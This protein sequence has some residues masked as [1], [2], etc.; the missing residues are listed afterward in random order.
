VLCAVNGVDLTGL[1]EEAIDLL[2]SAAK[3][4]RSAA[5]PLR[6]L[7]QLP[8]WPSHA[9]A[10]TATAGAGHAAGV[11]QLDK[12]L[13]EHESNSNPQPNRLPQPPSTQVLSSA[14]HLEQELKEELEQKLREQDERRRRWQQVTC[15]RKEVDRHPNVACTTISQGVAA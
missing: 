9:P 6:L 5:A 1:G 12:R 11:S 14:E 13:L 3:E 8:P 4:P 7:F 10:H 2:R 15:S